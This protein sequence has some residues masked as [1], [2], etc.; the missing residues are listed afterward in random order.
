M[1]VL[2][3]I[4]MPLKDG[5]EFLHPCLDSILSQDLKDFE[6][7]I[8][9][10][11]SIDDSVA[12]IERFK[13]KDDRIKLVENRWHGIPS[14]L[15]TGLQVAHGELITRMDCDDLMAPNK[16]S[17]LSSI[18]KVSDRKLVA[19]SK[20]KYIT[21]GMP[22]KGYQKYAGWLNRQI[23]SDNIF[24]SIYR[25][26]VIPSQAWMMYRSDV[27]EFEL[28]RFLA[29]PEDYDFCF[30]L[31]KLGF[32]VTH[33]NEEL[34]WWRDHPN[35]LTR[36]DP[37]YD[38]RSFGLFKLNKFL[39]LEVNSHD[40]LVLWGAGERGKK[41]ADNMIKRQMDFQWLTNNKAKC[42]QLIYGRM[43]RHP[44]ILEEIKQPKVIVAVSNPKDQSDIREQ[45]ENMGLV[46][47]N[48]FFFFF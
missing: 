32:N 47:G 25:E 42:D 13:S 31:Y 39:E 22:G 2:V 48:T 27:E 12:I 29:I 34:H 14:A 38:I 35:R 18:L 5:A 45:L 43:V 40:N 1:S 46:L 24:Q 37:R 23:E 28:F 15:E 6:L 7:I 10:D 17:A 8:V 19:L 4:I 36:T 9:N 16:L 20:V 41:L 3:S 33:V 44:T 30:R 11:H 21:E 26:C